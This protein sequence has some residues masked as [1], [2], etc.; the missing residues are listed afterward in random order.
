MT[1]KCLSKQSAS[2]GDTYPDFL[3]DDMNPQAF[4]DFQKTSGWPIVECLVSVPSIYYC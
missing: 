3:V 4:D 2:S 1:P